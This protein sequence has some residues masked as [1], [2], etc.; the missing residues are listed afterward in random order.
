MRMKY[1]LL[2][3]L[4]LMS[5]SQ[6]QDKRS[7][8]YYDNK[9]N[10][11][12]FGTWNSTDTANQ[13]T[14]VFNYG[15][16]NTGTYGYEFVW[17]SNNKKITYSR[18]YSGGLF[19]DPYWSEDRYISYQFLDDHH[20]RIT[21]EAN[22]FDPEVGPEEE[23]LTLQRELDIDERLLYTW[24]LKGIFRD[25][26]HHHTLTFLGYVNNFWKGTMIPI[27]LKS[28]KNANC[29]YFSEGTRLGLIDLDEADTTMFNYRFID[30]QLVLTNEN[31]T[32]YYKK[33]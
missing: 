27:N 30:D 12:L 32:L 26:G 25:I 29:G 20:I 9:F 1:L 22:E 15:E 16:G 10:T 5:C 23:T 8:P 11:M 6:L 33:E 19:S 31:N 13:A 21:I 28:N 24:E 4:L 3:I 18:H 2:L 7:K 14:F 17:E